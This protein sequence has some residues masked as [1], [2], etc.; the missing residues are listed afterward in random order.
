LVP[1]A[2]LYPRLAEFRAL[3]RTVDPA[4]VLRNN[5]TARVLDLPPGPGGGRP[6]EN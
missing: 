6:R 4:G 5:Y 3:C 2:R 1:F